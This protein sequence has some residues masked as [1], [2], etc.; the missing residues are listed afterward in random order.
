[1]YKTRET[2]MIKIGSRVEY[3]R[4]IEWG[5][6]I[7]DRG[8]VVDFLSSGAFLVKLDGGKSVYYTHERDV[9]IIK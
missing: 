2:T 1:M 4:S 9:R 3:V 5:P 8:E 7:G 6:S